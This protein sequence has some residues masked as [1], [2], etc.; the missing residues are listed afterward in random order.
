MQALHKIMNL[1]GG[2]TYKN[3]HSLDKD[4]EVITSTSK[5]GKSN[6]RSSRSSNSSSSN[7]LTP[8]KLGYKK[9][10]GTKKGKGKVTGKGR[11]NKTRSKRY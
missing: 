8:F 5:S 4:S 7:T 11:R 6:I 10:R 3:K 9:G 1:V 2:W